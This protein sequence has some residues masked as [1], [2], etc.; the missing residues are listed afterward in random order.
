MGTRSVTTIYEGDKP[1]LAF[2]RQMDGYPS[3]HG[4]ELVD[5]LMGIEMVNGI[6][7]GGEPPKLQQANG[8]GCLAAQIL[9]HFKMSVINYTYGQDGTKI[10]EGDNVGSIYVVPIGQEEEYNY[11][12]R[13]NKHN[14]VTGVSVDGQHYNLDEYH[15]QTI[16]KEERGG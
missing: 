14:K 15:G 11:D 8:A 12:V 1:L 4:Q 7:V 3:G 13:V 6:Q 5:F 16:E 9:T 10:R 2:Y